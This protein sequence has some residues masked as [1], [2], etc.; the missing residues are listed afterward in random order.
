[1]NILLVDDEPAIV[2]ALGPVLL[3]QG[4]TITSAESCTT[5][6][7]LVMVTKYIVVASGETLGFGLFAR[8]GSTG[9]EAH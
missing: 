2:T 3:S 4:H 9:S 8:S 7:P 1:M 6:A 5:Q